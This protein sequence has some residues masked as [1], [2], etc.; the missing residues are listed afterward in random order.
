[1]VLLGIG[2][3]FRTICGQTLAMLNTGLGL[4][5]RRVEEVAIG[6]DFFNEQSMFM[7]LAAF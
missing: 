7:P 2:G 6:H 5:G 4:A 3:T 1:V